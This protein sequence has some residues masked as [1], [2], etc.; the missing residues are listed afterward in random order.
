M[1]ISYM[2]THIDFHHPVS[3]IFYPFSND[4]Y[5]LFIITLLGN[6]LSF[7]LEIHIIQGFLGDLVAKNPPVKAGDIR[8]SNLISGLGRK[9]QS[10]TV[11]FPGESHRQRSLAG[12][13]P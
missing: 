10:I 13:S 3:H 7:K 5:C 12:Y 1:T 6:K 9:W 2:H 8:D 11:F 4:K